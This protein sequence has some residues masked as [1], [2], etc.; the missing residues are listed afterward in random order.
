MS[1]NTDSQFEAADAAIE[2]AASAFMDEIL[3]MIAKWEIIPPLYIIETALVEL[4][5]RLLDLAGDDG[6]SVAGPAT[7]KLFAALA[8]YRL[9]RLEDR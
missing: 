7:R 6:E 9:S 3:Q 8:E 4:G 2:K 5:S 1:D